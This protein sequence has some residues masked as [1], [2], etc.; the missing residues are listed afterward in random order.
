MDSKSTIP[1]GNVVR[2]PTQERRH[3]ATA[4]PALAQDIWDGPP[5]RRRACARAFVGIRPAAARQSI[6]MLEGARAPGRPRPGRNDPMQ[7]RPSDRSG[8]FEWRSASRTVTDDN[9]ILPCRLWQVA[10]GKHDQQV[11]DVIRDAIVRLA[12][13]PGELSARTRLPARGRVAL[14]VLEALGGSPTKASST[15]RSAAR[16]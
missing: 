2:F 8:R 6:E 9:P 3:A 16:G 7:P 14:P 4:A 5:G 11:H 10:G 1:R 13:T 15:S 12:F